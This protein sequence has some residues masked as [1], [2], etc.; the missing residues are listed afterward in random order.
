MRALYYNQ[1]LTLE[2]MDVPVPEAGEALIRVSLAG[3]CNTD[4]EIVKGY[5]GYRGILGHEF[6][7]TVEACS[8]E[9]WIGRRVAGE[10]NLGCGHCDMCRKGLAR[11]CATRQVLGIVNRHGA[12]AEYVTLLVENLIEMP[13]T[14]SDALAV[15]VEPLAAAFEILEQVHVAPQTEVAVI[16]DGKLAWMIVQVLKLTGAHVTVYGHHE[17]KCRFFR[18]QGIDAFSDAV[19]QPQSYSLVVEASGNISGLTAAITACQPRGVIVLKSTV[20]DRYQID[21]APLVIN[22][23]S[24]IGSRCGQFA[25]AI[26]ALAAEQ[27]NLAPLV[28]EAFPLSQYH[29]AFKQARS[30][31]TAKVVF[32]MK[33]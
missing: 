2:N 25:P 26:R 6:V 22:E 20:A 18:Q 32:D 5:M 14:I 29:E 11:H 4:L 16:G 31:Q 9:A 21:L 8:A 24:M 19:P 28:S 27:V 15:M 13:D 3:I 23:I 7:G 12:M 30:G 1:K 10:I 33:R 17:D